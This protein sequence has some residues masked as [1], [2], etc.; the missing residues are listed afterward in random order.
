MSTKL[1]YLILQCVQLFVSNFV[2]LFSLQGFRLSCVF[3]ALVQAERFNH[4]LKPSPAGG[5]Q[6]RTWLTPENIKL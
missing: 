4:F 6:I 2:G 5:K 3:R 1:F